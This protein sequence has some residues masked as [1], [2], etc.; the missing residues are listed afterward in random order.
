MTRAQVLR[1]LRKGR[2]GAGNRSG[3]FLLPLLDQRKGV[4]QNKNA[5]QSEQKIVQN[6]NPEPFEPCG[7]EKVPGFVLYF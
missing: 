3:L 1:Y 7:S 2:R 5:A 6:K 4:L